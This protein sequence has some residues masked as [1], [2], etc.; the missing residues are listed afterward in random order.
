MVPPTVIGTVMLVPP[1]YNAD[2]VKVRDGTRSSATLL[3][4]EPESQK[5]I[6][7]GPSGSPWKRERPGPLISKSPAVSPNPCV[8]EPA[9]GMFFTLSAETRVLMQQ[10]TKQASAVLLLIFTAKSLPET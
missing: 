10:R 2:P 7:L 1:E 9:I 3:P 5:P 8:A 4:S 6:K